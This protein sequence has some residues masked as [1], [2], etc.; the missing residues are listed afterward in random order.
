MTND[1]FWAALSVAGLLYALLCSGLAK[2]V[3]RRSERWADLIAW[4]GFLVFIACC[5]TAVFGQVS[6]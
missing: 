1:W 3:V 6:D 5:L 2:L 4:H